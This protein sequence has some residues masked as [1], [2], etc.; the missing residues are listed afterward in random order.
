MLP[1]YE[2]VVHYLA[3]L[4]RLRMMKL[5]QMNGYPLEE[6]LL[7]FDEGYDP[8][9][10]TTN[11]FLDML[12]VITGDRVSVEDPQ[13]TDYDSI[14]GENLLF[15]LVFHDMENFWL[16]DWEVER[17][18]DL[19]RSIAA[20]FGETYDGYWL[21]AGWLDE[22]SPI[23]CVSAEG[24]NI[25]SSALEEFISSWR[26]WDEFFQKRKSRVSPVPEEVYEQLW[27]PL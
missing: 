19:R 13:A 8:Y 24:W 12:K 14:P 11:M 1:D 25:M 20:C 18:Q 2:T 26:E 23:L 27:L 21:Y 22:E 4:D 15:R 7:V 9:C 5:M 6:K 10:D 3:C 17:Y 16:F